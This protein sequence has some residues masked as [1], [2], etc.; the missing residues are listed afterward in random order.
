MQL[1]RRTLIGALAGFWMRPALALAQSKIPT[2]GVISAGGETSFGHFIAAMVAR[3]KEL[4]WADGSNVRIEYRWAEGQNERVSAFAAEFARVK[5]DLIVTHS[6][7]AVTLAAKAA[8]E[9]PIVAASMGDP[10]KAG[11]A[12]S[13]AHPGGNI[14]GSS[15]QVEDLAPKRTALLREIVPNLRRLAV[16][17]YSSGETLGT[18]MLSAKAYA[19]TIGLDATAFPLKQSA[20]IATAFE[21]ARGRADGLF[22]TSTPFTMINRAEIFR[23]ALEARLPSVTGA[24]DYVAS[25][26]LVSYGTDFDDV[27]RRAAGYVDR[28]LRGE[29]PGDLPIQQSTRFELAVNLKTA[30]ALDLAVPQSILAGADEVIE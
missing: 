12:L 9:T 14:T 27:W 25:G 18:E 20:D 15:I 2:V 4:G 21:S 23:L 28:I 11:L 6:N 26:A 10:V 5:V 17:G 24:A 22:V 1:E 30:K 7:A 13:L 16:M 29:K 19:A 8:P 3:L